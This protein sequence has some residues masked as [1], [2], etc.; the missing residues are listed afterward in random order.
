MGDI[1]Q[2][3]PPLYWQVEANAFCRKLGEKYKVEKWGNI[4]GGKLPRN[5]WQR[6]RQFCVQQEREREGKINHLVKILATA[7]LTFKVVVPRH[8]GLPILFKL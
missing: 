7:L 1:Q 5:A 8:L 6:M 2:Q 4:F 3:E